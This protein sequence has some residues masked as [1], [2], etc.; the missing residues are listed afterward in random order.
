MHIT[1]SRLSVLMGVNSETVECALSAPEM[2]EKVRTIGKMVIPEERLRTYKK[3]LKDLLREFREKNPLK[4]GMS[5]EEL[6]TRLPDVD[7]QVF[8]TALEELVQEREV[9]I[10]KDRARLAGSAPKDRAVD[11]LEGIV[12]I[13]EAQGLTPP[14]TTEMMQQLN[15]TEGNLKD[16]LERLVYQGKIVKVRA[17]MYFGSANIEQLKQTVKD[18]LMQKK[19]ML[20][21]DFKAVLGLSRKYMIPLLEYLDTIKLTIRTGDKRVLRS[22]S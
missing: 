12:K 10:E 17:D 1:R 19:E 22:G 5:R 20:P 11:K 6:R 8:Q 18:Q 14:T 3:M 15:I 13:L 21:A 4:V 16:M 9:E 2:R 7:Q